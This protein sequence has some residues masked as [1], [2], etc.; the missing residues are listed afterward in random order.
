MLKIV[1]QYCLSHIWMSIIYRC[2]PTYT[3]HESMYARIHLSDFFDY[4]QQPLL[5]CHSNRK[6]EHFSSNVRKR[7]IENMEISYT[8]YNCS[9]YY[10]ITESGI[11]SSILSSKSVI[12]MARMKNPTIPE[13]VDVLAFVSPNVIF[14]MQPNTHKILSSYV[15]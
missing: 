11:D 14:A 2:K 1:K 3:R 9:L 10:L 8:L 5:L 12:R 4:F 15:R 7:D 13:T 6:L